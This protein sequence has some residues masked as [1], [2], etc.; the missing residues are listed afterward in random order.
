MTFDT[1]TKSTLFRPP[2]IEARQSEVSSITTE[3]Y[4]YRQIEIYFESYIRKTY[5][6][7]MKFLAI[8]VNYISGLRFKNIGKITY[9]G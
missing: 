5:Q 8:V 7:R 9:F 6:K 1:V 2:V 4:I 3:K